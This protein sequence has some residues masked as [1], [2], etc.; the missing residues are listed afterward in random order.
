VQRYLK[1][2]LLCQ[3]TDD[4]LQ[5]FGNLSRRPF[6]L[7]IVDRLHGC[8]GV[9]CGHLHCAAG[10]LLHNN[11][12]RQHRADL[13]FQRERLVGQLRIACPKASTVRATASANDAVSIV[14][15]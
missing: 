13:V 11:I 9:D 15:K 5:P 1:A 7:R 8:N 6:E 10:K 4:T 2:A 3:L 12:T 14:L